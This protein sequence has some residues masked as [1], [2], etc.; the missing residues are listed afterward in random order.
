[1]LERPLAD[2]GGLGVRSWRTRVGTGRR[3][4]VLAGLLSRRHAG[5]DLEIVIDGAVGSSPLIPLSPDI[6]GWFN[7]LGEPLG[8]RIFLMDLLGFTGAYA[9]L[10]LLCRQ[11]DTR[12]ILVVVVVVQVIVSAGP[13][14][15]STDVFSYLA[16]ARMGALHGVNPYT[17]GPLTILTDPI[18]EF[19]GADWKRS[20]TAYGPLYTLIS[21]PIALLGV[22][23]SVWAMKVLALLSS[24]GTLALTWYCA[25]RR[26]STA[27]WPC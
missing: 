7:N 27:S 3:A 17:H 10:V 24:F 15:L 11:L 13:I 2:R 19:V 1:M 20:S 5:G 4:H 8:Y 23:G 18:Y 25:G 26:V 14:L 16:Y 21:Y 6:T 22:T 12:L 9:G